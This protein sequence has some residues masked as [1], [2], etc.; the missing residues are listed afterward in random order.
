MTTAVPR[1]ALDL[2]A[3]AVAILPGGLLSSV[4]RACPEHAGQCACV[5]RD[6]AAGCLVFWCQPGGHHFTAR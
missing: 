3:G 2:P 1:S 5:G 4:R 6:Q